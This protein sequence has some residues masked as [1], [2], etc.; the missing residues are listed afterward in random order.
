MPQ[1]VIRQQPADL[2]LDFF[3]RV[4]YSQVVV[5][6]DENTAVHCY[7][8]HSKKSSWPPTHHPKSWRRTKEFNY[9]HPGVGSAYQPSAGPARTGSDN[10]RWG[11]W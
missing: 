3:A 9:L 6:A 1:I 8:H 7:P 2:I 11:D 4:T 5:L 10:W